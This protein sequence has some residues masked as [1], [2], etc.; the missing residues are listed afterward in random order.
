MRAVDYNRYLAAI[1]A[2]ND[3]E[4]SRARD[5]LRKIQADMIAEY[6]V[7]DNDVDYLIRQFR[8]NI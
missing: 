5:L 2:A 3:C 7:S 6:G 8:Y 4:P 1:K